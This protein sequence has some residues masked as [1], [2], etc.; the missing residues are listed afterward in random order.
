[1]ELYQV[2]DRSMSPEMHGHPLRSADV[3]NDVNQ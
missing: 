1:M 3:A 2:I